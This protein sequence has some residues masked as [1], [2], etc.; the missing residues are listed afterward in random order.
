MLG[1]GLGGVTMAVWGYGPLGPAEVRVNGGTI[2]FAG[3][4]Q[5]LILAM[6]LLAASQQVPASRLVDE[7]WDSVKP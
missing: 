1:E 7:L 2:E 5:R 3:A 6:L 4:R